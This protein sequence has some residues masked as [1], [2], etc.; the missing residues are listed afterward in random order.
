M[1]VDQLTRVEFE[2]CKPLVGSIVHARRE[3]LFDPE[4]VAAIRQQLDERIVLVLPQVHFSNDEQL[5]FTD[6][7]GQRQVLTGNSTTD[8]TDPV[9]QVTL[10]KKINRA[11]EYVLGTFFYHMDGMPIDAPPPYATL[12]S[13][14][15][16]AAVG[17]QTQFANTDAAYEALSDAEKEEYGKLRVIHTVSSALRS[18][19]DT[20]PEKHKY[21]LG[22]GVQ[23]ERPLVYT[24]KSGRKSLLI[25]ASAD[26]VEGMDVYRGRALIH[27]LNEWAGQPDFSYTHDWKEGD[28][29]VWVNTAAMHRVI[30][31]DDDSGRMM[32]RTSVGGDA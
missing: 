13:A 30:P 16:V 24:R 31:Y 3:D 18:I 12:L 26:T 32:H 9:Y 2:P 4:V 23:G 25:G 19:A 29:A 11:P 14:R 8:P 28:L 1:S 6:L 27:R 20:I 21:K 7:I 10:D 22:I 15:R 17:G 5:A